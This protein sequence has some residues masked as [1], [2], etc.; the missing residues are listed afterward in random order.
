MAFL[1]DFVF[2][3]YTNLI[4][5]WLNDSERRF[6]SSTYRSNYEYKHLCNLKQHFFVQVQ[7]LIII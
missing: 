3:S 5:Y 7:A 2:Y 1:G 6:T 4:S